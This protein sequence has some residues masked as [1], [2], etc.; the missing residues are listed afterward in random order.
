MWATFSGVS[1]K[2]VE[3][4]LGE[5]TFDDKPLKFLLANRNLEPVS[6]RCCTST[7]GHSP[8][9]AFYGVALTI[10]PPSSPPPPPPPSPPPSPQI[11]ARDAC[12]L[13]GSDKELAEKIIGVL[14]EIRGLTDGNPV[15]GEEDAA[16]EKVRASSTAWDSAATAQPRRLSRCPDTDTDASTAST[17]SLQMVLYLRVVHSYD[18]FSGQLVA[19]EDGLA[20]RMGFMTVPNVGVFMGTPNDSWRDNGWAVAD[21]TDEFKDFPDSTGT[22]TEETAVNDLV[23]RNTKKIKDELYLC[24]LR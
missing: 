2:T 8:P 5:V 22:L 13:V 1:V 6:R 24:P 15:T 18:F 21:H 23:E 19:H 7:L 4:E 12:I 10:S 16:L 3:K 14:D 17:A 11:R 9:T 20:Q